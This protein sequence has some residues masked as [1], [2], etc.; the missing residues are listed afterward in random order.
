MQIRRIWL[1]CA[2]LA[3]V[4]YVMIGVGFAP[5]CTPSV[6]FWRLAAWVVTRADL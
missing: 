3:G 1:A 6:F 2:F 5:R 4:V